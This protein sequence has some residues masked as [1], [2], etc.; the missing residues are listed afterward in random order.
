MHSEASRDVLLDVTGVGATLL[1]RVLQRRAA[2][3]LADILA[4]TCVVLRLDRLQDGVELLGETGY[5]WIPQTCCWYSGQ[6][7]A[8]GYG[9]LV[10]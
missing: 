6:K 7:L 10:P 4:D 1:R 3:I 9:T 8:A 2:R 5:R